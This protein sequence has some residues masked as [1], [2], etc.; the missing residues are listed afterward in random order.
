MNHRTFL[1]R[2]LN[3]VI[4]AA[5]LIVYQGVAIAHEKQ[6]EIAQLNVEIEELEATVSAYEKAY[7]GDEEESEDGGSGFIDGAYTGTSAGY[8]GD[9]TVE[10]VVEDG[11]IAE[12]NIVSADGEDQEYMDMAMQVAE[13]IVSEQSVE[14]DTVTGA[15]LSSIGIRN[16]A[17][18]A[19]QQAV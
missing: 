9:I 14:V 19:L 4:V 13:D 2:L 10:V 17:I 3:L 18:L 8:G 16:A 5:L 7:S 1:T 15:T 12:V 11:A 6:E